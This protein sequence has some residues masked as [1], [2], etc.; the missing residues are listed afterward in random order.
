MDGD[1]DGVDE[2]VADRRAHRIALDGCR[3]REGRGRSLPL[4]RAR[5]PRESVARGEL[6]A[7][8]VAVLVVNVSHEWTEVPMVETPP[9]SDR[10]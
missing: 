3:T 5:T 9:D 8:T 6:L 1:V 7:V 10:G 4:S 2:D